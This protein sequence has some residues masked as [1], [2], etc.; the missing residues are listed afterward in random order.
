MPNN[1]QPDPGN[2]VLIRAYG[3]YWK[4]DYV[5]WN[6]AKR[7]FGKRRAD[8][9]GEDV[10]VYEQRGIYILYNDFVP[11]YVGKAEGLSI[12]SRIKSHWESRRKG[13]R[14][15]GFSWFGLRTINKDGSLRALTDAFH[16]PKDWLIDTLEAL[17]ISAIDPPL[18]SRR[19]KLRQATLLYQSTT[20]RPAGI[21]ERLD[22]IERVVKGLAIAHSTEKPKSRSRSEKNGSRS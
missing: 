8:L 12:G 3:E 9:K 4:A 1:P 2:R 15:N 13:P 5:R 10:D 18:N 20:D 19:E 11:V 17:L 6:K 21:Q 7:L 22:S 16:P 14:W